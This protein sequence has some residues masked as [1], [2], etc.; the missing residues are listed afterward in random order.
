MCLYKGD[1]IL[2]SPR[3]VG[4]RLKLRDVKRLFVEYLVRVRHS[5]QAQRPVRPKVLVDSGDLPPKV[6][7]VCDDLATSAKRFPGKWRTRMTLLLDRLEEVTV[8]GSL[9]EAL[10]VEEVPKF[11]ARYLDN[12]KVMFHEWT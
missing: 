8:L 10:F 1:D 7:S 2:D 4:A 12:A 3:I 5:A 6:V 9:P 11:G